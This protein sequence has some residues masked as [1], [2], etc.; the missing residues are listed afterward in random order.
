[1]KKYLIILFLINFISPRLYAADLPSLKDQFLRNFI[2]DFVVLAETN[3]PFGVR[4]IG[5][6]AGGECSEP[7]PLVCPKYRMYIG[8]SSLDEEPQRQLFVLHDS[9]GWEF[10]GWKSKSKDQD[11]QDSYSIFEIREK[12]ILKNPQNGNKFV[13]GSKF[14]EIGVNPWK[15]YVLQKKQPDAILKSK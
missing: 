8:V 2:N 12:I 3:D 1:M 6:A 13:W 11:N 9:Y 7:E 4:I 10:L 5:L 14:Y 15:G